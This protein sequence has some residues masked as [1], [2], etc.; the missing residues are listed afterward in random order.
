MP[1]WEEDITELEEIWERVRENKVAFDDLSARLTADYKRAS[2]LTRRLAQATQGPKI[3]DDEGQGK[4]R[5]ERVLR[6]LHKLET[7]TRIPTLVANLPQDDYIGVSNT[8]NDLRLD[9]D[10]LVQRTNKLWS[11][12]QAGTEWVLL[13][14]SEPPQAQEPP[15]F[16]PKVVSGVKLAPDSEEGRYR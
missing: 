4:T 5:K 11:L 16:A 1:T 9:S 12:T 14:T 2:F 13:H 15:R 3:D 8:L 7:P 6:A 10:P